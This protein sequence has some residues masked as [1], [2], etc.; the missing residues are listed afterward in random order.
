[1]VHCR[2]PRVVQENH[3]G[4]NGKNVEKGGQELNNEESINQ[5]GPQKA[6]A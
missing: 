3:R 5:K 2:Q 4:K 6:K 1:M